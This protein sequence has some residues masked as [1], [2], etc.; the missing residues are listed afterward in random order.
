MSLAEL[1][2]E[3]RERRCA[4]SL[5]IGQAALGAFKGFELVDLIQK[6]LVCG[7]VLHNQFRLAIDGEH[8]WVAGPAHPG[9]EVAGVA[10]EVAERMDILTDVDGGHEVVH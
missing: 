1:P 7:G 3:L 10:L 5:H 2:F 6:F 9:D 8:D 4:A